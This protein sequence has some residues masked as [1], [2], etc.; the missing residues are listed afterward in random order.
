HAVGYAMIAYQCAYLKTHNLIEFY[1]ALLNVEATDSYGKIISEA[2]RNGIEVVKVDINQSE[3]DFSYKGNKIYWG[4]SKVNGIGEKAANEI[5]KFRKEFNKKILL[6]R[7]LVYGLNISWRACNKG[8][9]ETLIKIGVFESKLTRKW[10]LYFYGR[11]NRKANKTDKKEERNTIEGRDSILTRA[12]NDTIE[13]FKNIEQKE[14]SEAELNQ[15]E[16]DAYKINIEYSPF[17]INNRDKKIDRLVSDGRVGNFSDGKKYVI[18]QFK[19]ILR[20]KDKNGN[21]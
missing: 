18:V 16:F 1:T 20:K 17:R 19:E 9:M 2:L 8:V 21:E 14:F 12:K 13:E 10:L 4:L 7:F 15:I 11:F 3:I 5:I 6:S